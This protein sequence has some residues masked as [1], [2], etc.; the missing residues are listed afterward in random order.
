MTYARTMAFGL[1]LGLLALVGRAAVNDNGDGT[2]TI[3]YTAPAHA[4]LDA[5][6]GLGYFS[7]QCTQELVA[8]G[9]CLLANLGQ[10]L[11]TTTATAGMAAS[12]RVRAQMVGEEIPHLAT[13]AAWLDYRVKSVLKAYRDRGREVMQERMATPVDT[14]DSFE[15]SP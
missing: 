6:I 5:A 10:P 3:A 1:A 4:A 12:G 11:P 14:S 2:A 7:A 9:V 13:A 15:A 8:A